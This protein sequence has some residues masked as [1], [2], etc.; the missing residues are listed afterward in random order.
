MQQPPEII[1]TV[2]ND[3]SYDQRMQRI[4]G[5]LAAAGYKV[6][7]V[8]RLMPG[9]LALDEKNYQQVRLACRNHSGKLFYL[10]YNWR[11]YQ[12]LKKQVTGVNSSR[13]SALC[14][15]DLD[16]IIP[17]LRVSE[18]MGLPGVYDAHEL[19]TEL[20][21]VK[22]RRLVAAIWNWVEQKVV[23]K[24]KFGYTVNE[25][26]AGELK[27][28]Y[29]VNYQVIRNLPL[30]KKHTPNLTLDA[31][32][33][34]AGRFFLYQ[35]AVNEGRCFEMLIPAMKKVAANLVIAGDGNFFKQAIALAKNHDVEEKVH[36]LGYVKPAQLSSLT[37][38]AYAGIT[39]FE[40]SGL[41]QY[42]SLANR[43]FDYIQGGIPQ[44]CSAY[45]EY[46]NLNNRYPCA[47]M[48]KDQTVEGIASSLNKLLSDNVFY[49]DLKRHCVLAAE[50][51]C[52][53]NEAEKLITYWK[54]ILPI[55]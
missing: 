33:L 39:L 42:Y 35:G 11:L 13:Q 51:L 21:E 48:L 46:E 34:P 24:F 44:L 15:I 4:C 43:Y 10:E 30:R 7:L 3:L 31:L 25:F 1:F 18:K 50:E 40:N 49:D 8:G 38:L 2:T 26:I 19:F 6:T 37:P 54:T 52:W 17:V 47:I 20:T 27:R 9:S 28:R 23:P 32:T 45:P 22:R 36:F 5:T 29:R 41:N 12:Y 53:E 16:T 14:A 55:K